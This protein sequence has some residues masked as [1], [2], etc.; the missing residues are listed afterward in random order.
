MGSLWWR[1][2]RLLRLQ[3]LAQKAEEIRKAALAE[4]CKS[5]ATVNFTTVN[6]AINTDSQEQRNHQDSKERKSQ[7]HRCSTGGQKPPRSLEQQ[8]SW[9]RQRYARRF[10][11]TSTTGFTWYRTDIGLKAKM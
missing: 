7:Q 11:G 8:F 9:Q 6:P 2:N 5:L 10:S 1:I 4:N 3:H